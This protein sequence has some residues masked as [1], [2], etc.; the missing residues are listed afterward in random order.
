[1]WFQSAT[2]IY[3]ERLKPQF[4]AVVF[5]ITGPLLG[6]GCFASTSQIEWPDNHV[7]AMAQSFLT[8]CQAPNLDQLSQWIRANLEGVSDGAAISI[9]RDNLIFCNKNGGLEPAE[10]VKSKPDY[11]WLKAV[12]VKSGTWLDAWWGV[13]EAGKLT[14]GGHN[15]GTPPEKD[16][17]H[18]LSDAGIANFIKDVVAKRSQEGLFSGIVMV[19]RGTKTVV[20]ASGG[21]ANRATKI[22]IVESSQFTIGSMGKMFTAVAIGQL[23]DQGKV[24]LSD[25]VGKFFAAYPNAIVRDK[26]TVGMLLSHTSGMGDEFLSRRTA[27][28]MQVGVKRA[29]E[30]MPLLYSREALKF[31]PGT[32]WAYS[33]DGVVLAGAIVEKVSGEDYPSYLR[34]HIFAVAGM[35]DSDPNNVPRARSALV[36]PYSKKPPADDGSQ[37]WTE[38]EHDLGSPAGGAISTAADLIRFADHLRNGKLISKATLD[39]LTR[40]NSLSADELPYGTGFQ[41]DEIYGRE[42]IGHSGG[43][44][45]VST[46]LRLFSGSTYTVVTLANLDHPA[47][48]YADT[49]A[50][51]LVAAK[52]KKM[53]GSH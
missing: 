17:P 4:Y 23:M 10:I 42:T 49:V 8:L 14:S 7:A 19:A 12:G 5:C 27:S 37:E 33:N 48:L 45:G 40:R 26:V 6:F 46:S 36:I 34:R 18:D 22:P 53:T 41:V 52:L 16:L 28:M 25:T 47:W 21:F 32:A 29:D 11:L 31:E 30:Y 9:A 51:A 20:M 13:N 38:A 43:F 2:E 3:A 39:T 44:P 1:M 35:K 24:S 15:P 50:Y